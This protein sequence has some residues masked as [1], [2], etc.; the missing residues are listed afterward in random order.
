MLA[1]AYDMTPM[2]FAPRNRGLL[3]AL[4]PADIRADIVPEDWP[5]ALTMAQAFFAAAQCAIPLRP[6]L[7]PLHRGAAVSK[8]L[9]ISPTD[10]LKPANRKMFDGALAFRNQ[11]VAAGRR[12][13]SAAGLLSRRANSM[14]SS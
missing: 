9:R 3:D 13:S 8:P 14:P 7:C 5:R 6:T 4:P 11:S 1:P 2:A 10:D 12:F